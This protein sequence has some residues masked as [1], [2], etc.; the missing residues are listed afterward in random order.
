MQH[1][2][3][4]ALHLVRDI[5]AVVLRG[6]GHLLGDRIS[7]RVP[8]WATPIPEQIRLIVTRLGI[9]RTRH[10]VASAARIVAPAWP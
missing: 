10:S 1:R 5:D 4:A 6:L 3:R 8:P 2:L 9:S 7:S